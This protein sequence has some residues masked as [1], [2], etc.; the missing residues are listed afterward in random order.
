MAITAK[1]YGLILERFGLEEFKAPALKPLVE[2]SN[3]NLLL[4]RMWRA[5]YLD[6]VARGVFRAVHPVVLALERAGY[7]WRDKLVQR[8]Y[9]PMLEFIVARVVDRFWSDLVSIVVFGSLARGK[10]KPESD[11]D[12]LVVSKGLPENYSDRLTAFREA[13]RGVE[14]MRLKLW[15]ANGLYPLIDPILLTPEEADVTQPFYLDM[16][17]ASV[18]LFDRGGFMR[19][20]LDELKAELAKLGAKRIEL[21]DGRWYWELVP[22]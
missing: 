4:Y 14:S 16:V 22:A 11:I 7:R 15:R 10:A 5:G 21:P 17:E 13:L 9:L 2:T 1:V 18:I 8:D 6:R 20:R 12:L 3:V 19:R